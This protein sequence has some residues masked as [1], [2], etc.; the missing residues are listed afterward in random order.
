VQVLL[1]FVEDV[2][3][4]FV[5]V[6]SVVMGLL[7][8]VHG[9]EDRCGELCNGADD[10]DVESGVDE[11][12]EESVEH[13]VEGVVGEFGVEELEETEDG[14][15]LEQGLEA[16]GLHVVLGVEEELGLEEIPFGI[17]EGL[18]LEETLPGVTVVHGAEDE[19]GLEEELLGDGDA[20][21]FEI[22]LEE[23]VEEAGGLQL[24]LELD[25][26]VGITGELGVEEEL[27]LAVLEDE[28][29]ETGAG[30]PSLGEVELVYV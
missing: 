15:E 24:E 10:D 13:V 4:V 30:Q 19:L 16:E 8:V 21:E 2:Q 18:E 27:L 11:T 17:E 28:L 20:F 14:V 26:V 6:D 25:T 5:L 3:D 12:H 1:V 9:V 29:V 7:D 23:E 22:G